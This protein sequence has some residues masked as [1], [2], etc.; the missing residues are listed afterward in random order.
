MF[1]DVVIAGGGPAGSFAALILAQAGVRVRICDRAVF[2]RDK[3][4]G[5]TL[6]PG[7]L[8][9][10]ARHL[11][12]SVVLAASIPI[13]G[14]VLTGP[15][16]VSVH[17]RY[18]DGVHGRAITRRALDQ[19]LIT[20]A[21]AAGAIVEERTRVIGPLVTDDEVRGV[22]VRGKAGGEQ[23]RPAR[24]TIAAEGRRSP[25]ASALGLARQPSTPRRWAI[26]AP[27]SLLEST[28]RSDAQLRWRFARAV[29]AS[30][31]TVLGPMAVDV[32][33]PGRP[34]LLLA[35]DAA[36]FIDPMTGDGLRL[37][38]EGAELAADVTLDV[39]A[40]RISRTRMARELGDRRRARFRAKW[41]FNR[42]MR[43]LV[44]YPAGV[45]GAAL[46]A[47]WLPGL[48]AQMIRYAGDCETSAKCRE[49]V[50]Q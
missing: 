42:A 31:V 26:G 49:P 40:G 17:G 1:E 41:R 16:D 38:L 11:H 10:L 25:L 7:A 30:A 50:N 19:W 45:A 37:A 15:G 39:L 22:R 18:G 14:M 47:R 4:C 43:R 5:D 24:V 2:P 44:D 28:V 35:G 29:R 32:E 34:G 20:T 9:V 36:G 46:A 13:D 6:N 33:M 3:L 27:A 48:F 21:S 23:S 8:A 12:T